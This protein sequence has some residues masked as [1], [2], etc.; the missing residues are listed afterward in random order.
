MSKKNVD[1]IPG[2]LESKTPENGKKKSRFSLKIGGKLILA[3][4][5]VGLV[6]VGIVSVISLTN[7][8]RALEEQAFNSLVSSRDIKKSQIETFFA[9]RKGDMGVLVD[10]VATLQQKAINKLSADR[11]VKQSATERYFETSGDQ[12]ITFSSNQM[13]IDAM[14]DFSGNFKN[15]LNETGVEEEELDS[16]QQELLTYYTGEFDSEYKKQNSEKP[17]NAQSLFSQL[18]NE[19]IALQYMYIRANHHPLGSKHMLNSFDDSSTYSLTHGKVHPIIREYLEKFGY[20]DIFLVDSK[21]GDIVYSVSKEVDYT[22]SLI[23]GPYARTNFGEAF[24]KANELVDKNAIVFVDYAQYTPSYEAPASFLASPIY[25]GN[26]KIGVAMFQLP[27]DKLNEI[28]G[29]RS[30]LGETGETV[31]IGDDMLM[32]SDSY[33]DPETH[34][35]VASFKK[36]ETGKFENIA[37][38]SALAGK[39]GDF[40][41]YDYKER[42]VLC[43]YSP[44]KVFDKTWAMVSKINIAEA[45][46]PK[47]EKGEYF[48]KKYTEKYGYYDLFLINPNGYCFYTASKEPDY[49]TNLIN[50][51][52]SSS[53]LGELIRKVSSVRQ[54]GIV[55]FLPYAP[56]NDAPAAFIAQPI[57]NDDEIELIV[58]LQISID[59]INNIMQL[60]SGMGA[61]GETYLVGEDKL[62]RSDSFLDPDNHT[63]MASF[64]NPSKGSVNTDAAKDALSGNSDSRIIIN[65]NGNPV[66]SAYTPVKVDGFNWALI[67]EIDEAEAFASLQSTRRLII[68]ISISCVIV[69]V[70]VGVIFGRSISKS[71]TNPINIMI[72]A[73]KW[74]ASGDYTKQVDINR[75]DELGVLADTFNVMVRDLRTDLLN[76]KV[77]TKTVYV[78]SEKLTAISN[79][80]ASGAEKIVTQITSVSG[81]TEEMSGNIN[82]M[83]SAAEEMS[84]NATTVSSTS[85]QLSNNMNMVA[86]AVEEMTSS[87]NDVAKNSNDA[88]TVA[89]HATEI[90]AKATTT[91][92]ILGTAARE[93]GNVTEVIKRIAEQTNLLALNATI[94]AASAGEAGKGF[95]VVANEIKELANQS[96]QAAEN[97]ANKIGGVQNN[98]TA[99]VKIIDE[100]TGIIQSINESVSTINNAVSEQTNAANEIS[101][102]VTAASSGVEDIAASISEVATGSSDVAKNAGEASTCTNEVSNN[103]GGVNEAVTES[104]KNAHQVNVSAEDLAKVSSELQTVVN[105][106]KLEV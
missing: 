69:I 76:I 39:R 77:N 104:S 38:T 60:R 74:V 18:D 28:V 83:A 96:A 103:I 47:D 101:A 88:S 9:E 58:A 35:V 75:S 33:L 90:S 46:C 97:I 70:I 82:M 52:F 102:N 43:S 8:S 62:M 6:P 91:M 29:Q 49:R 45:F 15:V 89:N 44:V 63:V 87:I 12:L 57:V 40:I 20:Y 5:L 56:S 22:T 1:S 14:K 84:V 51:K 32:R 98:T 93:I 80:M 71:I 30:G 42:Q 64:A 61:T 21:S 95:A 54:Y 31:L 85:E 19:S 24:R 59:A 11:A 99:A 3:F 17:S 81:T 23:N 66:L 26:K 68:Y 7:S 48:F 92:D 55:D 36:P 78:A 100:V 16:M 13:V 72:E 65:Y 53:N 79:Q 67:A 27:I 37:V 94:E 50:G 41:T 34:S 4:L 106:F 2:T 25:D 105:R 10:I 73:I 86:S